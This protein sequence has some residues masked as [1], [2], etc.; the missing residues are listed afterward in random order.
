MD[1]PETFSAVEARALYDEF[2]ASGLPLDRW[3]E[4]QGLAWFTNGNLID[5]LV[6]PTTGRSLEVV[7]GEDL[8]P[9]RFVAVSI[10]DA[11]EDRRRR[12]DC[13]ETVEAL[14]RI[15]S[16]MA[17][18]GAELS[19]KIGTFAYHDTAHIDCAWIAQVRRDRGVQPEAPAA[20]VGLTFTGD[21]D[22]VPFIDG[23][24][25]GNDLDPPRQDVA[26][27]QTL[28]GA[29]AVAAWWRLTGA[30]LPPEEIPAVRFDTA[31]PVDGRVAVAIRIHGEPRWVTFDTTE[32]GSELVVTPDDHDVLQFGDPKMF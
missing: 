10:F 7:A 31:P 11:A 16:A 1:I 32:P 27:C 4:E 22:V 12:G 14:D 9:V 17:R 13:G 8:E 26:V 3:A 2:R 28:A 5:L 21:P 23:Q 25:A 19:R 6:E 18:R 30:K 20:V 29:F 15:I 24:L